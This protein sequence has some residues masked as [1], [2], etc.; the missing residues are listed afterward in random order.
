MSSLTTPSEVSDADGGQAGS[1]RRRRRVPPTQR[2]VRI[3]VLITF[4]FAAV[5]LTL[6]AIG[7]EKIP[8][9]TTIAG[10]EIGGLDRQSAINK[11]NASFAQQAQAPMTLKIAQTTARVPSDSMGISVNYPATVDSVLTSRLN[12]FDS[13][14]EWRGGGAGEL[15]FNLDEP[16][17]QQKLDDLSQQYSQAAREPEITYNGTKPELSEPVIGRTIDRDSAA[18]AIMAHY[19]RAKG[20][21]ELPMAEQQPA[22]SADQAKA[23]LSG[24][25][26]TAVS[27]P[28]TVKVGDAS[29]EASAAA[30]AKSLTFQVK[31]GQLRPVVDGAALHASLGPALE[32]VDTA[33]K[34]ARWDVSSGKPVLVPAQPGNG[35]TDDHVA[36][37]VI[38][39][40]DK[41]GDDRRVEMPLG[42]LA[43]KLSTEDAASLN[44]TEKVSSFTQKFP[45]AAYRYQNIG[46]AAKKV[47]NTLLTP[48]DVF[49]MNSKVGERTKANGFTT[50]FVVGEGGR[51]REDMGGGVS[52]AATTLWTA[53]FYAGLERVEQGSHLIWISRY[54]PGLEAT[55]AWG[56]LDLKFRND[57]PSGLL[58]TTKMT[59][60]ALTVTMWGTKQYDEVKAVS[61]PKQNVKAFTKEEASGPSCVPQGGV[62]G[63][64]ID[65]DRIFMKGGQQVKKQTY[66]TSYIP[67]AAVTCVK[68]PAK[69]T[70]QKGAT[71]AV[72]SGG[73]STS[74]A[75]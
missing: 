26:T 25:A 59:K 32:K 13:W 14:R 50:G 37:S 41:Q 29:A 56:Q 4:W 62:P 31:D 21:I 8:S 39:V 38:S 17:L 72:A 23:V 27:Q 43:P 10:V 71:S 35:V 60:T 30:I 70:P 64:S 44:I 19:L 15:V 22:V 33:A 9:G 5:M 28:V 45:Y 51:F 34:D 1:S 3:A 52:T 42:P 47:N 6:I 49:S 75:R 58:I 66:T 2:A 53:A 68:A 40:L 61:G 57:S 18:G 74:T 65:V 7:S 54:R 36:D 11:L 16:T 12:P 48:G 69:P 20:P 73:G 55:V 67:A 24:I 63:F 46:M